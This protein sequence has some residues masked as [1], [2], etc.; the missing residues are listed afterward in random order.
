MYQRQWRKAVVSPATIHDYLARINNRAWVLRECVD[1]VPE[2]VDAQRALLEFGL[3]ATDC[4]IVVEAGGVVVADFGEDEEEEG[5]NLS[6]SMT[7]D[8]DEDET[9]DADAIVADSNSVEDQTYRYASERWRRW[10]QRIIDR[11]DPRRLT[12]EQKQLLSTR[13]RIFEYLDRLST[14]ECILGGGESAQRNYDHKFFKRFRAENIVK[15]AVQFARGENLEAL[16]ALFTYHGIETLPYRLAILANLPETKSPR[17]YADLLPVLEEPEV[18]EEE[19]MDDGADRDCVDWLRQ[20]WRIPDWS[21]TGK[22]AVRADNKEENEGGDGASE[23]A[24]SSTASSEDANDGSFLY[25]FLPEYYRKFETVAL[26]KSLVGE[27]FAVRAEELEAFAGQVSVLVC[28]LDF[29]LVC[30]YVRI[31]SVQLCFCRSSC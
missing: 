30:L 16:D 14:Y 31:R 7:T 17:E 15:S 8:E 1:R 23:G 19:I 5:P 12:K 28:P 22:F 29:G 25:D 11:I 10:R 18:G 13:K 3:R 24:T 27:W 26:T 20:V 2:D 6:S 4:K 9:L 21:E